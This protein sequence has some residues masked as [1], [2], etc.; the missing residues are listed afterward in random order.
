MKIVIILIVTLSIG[1]SSVAAENYK[2]KP[3]LRIPATK[4]IKYDS[5]PGSSLKIPKKG[6]QVEH[7]YSLRVEMKKDVT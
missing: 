1:I 6:S 7:M 3:S 2:Q 5:K 4:F